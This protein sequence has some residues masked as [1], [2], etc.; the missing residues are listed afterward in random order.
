[1][2]GKLYLEPIHACLERTNGINLSDEND[3]AHRLQ[4]LGATLANLAV[5]AN[6]GLKENWG[7]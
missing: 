1:M 3:A 5:A 2:I 4:T 6:N 7:C